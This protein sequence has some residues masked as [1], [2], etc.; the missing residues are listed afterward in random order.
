[1]VQNWFFDVLL[2][3]LKQASTY[4]IIKTILLNEFL[5]P[6]IAAIILILPLNH[7]MVKGFLQSIVTDLSINWWIYI[8]S[9]IVILFTLIL[10]TFYQLYKAANKN[11]AEAL[12]NE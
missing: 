11:P 3:E 6:S 12:S 5:I 1:L 10:T 2:K 8:L 9:I 7:F 4:R